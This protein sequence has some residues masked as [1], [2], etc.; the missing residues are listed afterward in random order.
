S[1]LYY[2][3]T[4]Q[5]AEGVAAK[6]PNHTLGALAYREVTTPP[7]FDLHPNIVPFVAVESYTLVDDA[8]WDRVMAMHRE[9]DERTASFGIYDY[10]YGTMYAVPRLGLDHLAKVYD[11]MHDY[12]V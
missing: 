2:A 3:W 7:S 8:A 11:A 1:D 9:W 6:F 5:V 12:G 4:N 10:L